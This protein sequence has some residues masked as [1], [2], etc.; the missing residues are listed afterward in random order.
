LKK[1]FTEFPAVSVSDW[2]KLIEK[3]LKGQDYDK[4]LVWK[5]EEGFSVQPFY[6]EESIPGKPLGNP[7][8]MPQSWHVVDEIKEGD[9]QQALHEAKKSLESGAEG[10]KIHS[11]W[12]QNQ[13]SGVKLESSGEI[14]KFSSNLLEIAQK[15]SQEKS[16]NIANSGLK[17]F[18]DS[19]S[20]SLIYIKAFATALNS[21]KPSLPFSVQGAFFQDPF[22]AL[23]ICGSFPQKKSEVVST[24]KESISFAEKNLPDF[25][26]ISVSG[27][28]FA[29]T[30]SNLTQEIAFSLAI[31]S[32]YL[33]LLSKEGLAPTQIS[34]AI[35]FRFSV[36]ANY[37]HEIAKFRSFRFLWNQVL[38]AYGVPETERTCVIYA[39]T[40]SWNQS[41][42]D[43][44]VN[45]IRVTTESMSAV[46]GGVNSLHVQPFDSVYK[47]G[48]DFSKRIARNAQLLLRHESY[49]D[50]VV[51]PSSGSYYIDH[52]TYNFSENA[53]K[54]FQEVENEGGYIT[55]F[56]SGKIQSRIKT[57]A[58]IKRKSIQTKQNPILGTTQYP[59]F[60]EKSS[61]IQKQAFLKVGK[62]PFPEFQSESDITGELIPTWR[63]AEEFESLRLE[64]ET[65]SKKLGAPPSVGLLITGHRAMRTAR[66]SFATNFFGVAG[67][68]I[69]NL[70]GND[71]PLDAINA[72]IEKSPDI[73]VFCSSDEEYLG[74]ATTICPMIR[75][76]LPKTKIVVAGNPS[77][78]QEEMIQ[79]GISNF[80]HVK[81]PLLESLKKYVADLD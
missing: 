2:I 51:D 32:E 36:G 5:T 24:I 64:V 61:P 42:F 19:S 31:G 71:D 27:N 4:K 78:G 34:R 73:I 17:I 30:G 8:S 60:S 21:K 43:P 52:L 58:E 75:S 1:L 18:W 7:P 69:T 40:S 50:K 80:I 33:S 41:L 47:E 68:A 37:F 23:T 46:L 62:A 20:S 49:L 9:P 55:S 65:L 48:D 81:T 66:A 22:N 15:A 53:W 6:T 11:I 38:E 16:S 3:D 63:A 12:N 54:L 74:L 14:Q 44:Y 67:F 76:K 79:A 72:L 29:E 39:E 25:Q 26:T 28:N 35:C 59:D 13:V 45:M 10:L 57:I 77:E 70:G 56:Q